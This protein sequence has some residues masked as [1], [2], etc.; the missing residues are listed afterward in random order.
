MMNSFALLLC[1]SSICSTNLVSAEE[2]HIVTSPDS[3]CPTREY[4]EPC[5]TLEQYLTNPSLSS[6]T[7]L[8]VE[9]GNHFVKESRRLSGLNISIASEGSSTNIIFENNAGLTFW[10]TYASVHDIT[11]SS[12]S[13]YAEIRFDN[14]QEL[15][16]QDCNF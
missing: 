13:E 12:I 1:F 10:Q 11:F 5:L 9:S 16:I 7:I 2:F 14:T 3:S 6:N 8:V 15:M 4:G